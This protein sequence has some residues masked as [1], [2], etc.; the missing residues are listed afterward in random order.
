M[1]AAPSIAMKKQD[2]LP[3]SRFP[4]TSNQCLFPVHRWKIK[5]VSWTTVIVIEQHNEHSIRFYLTT[6][7]KLN[8]EKETVIIN[9]FSIK[10]KLM[11]LNRNVASLWFLVSQEQKVILLT[12]IC[13]DNSDVLRQASP[14]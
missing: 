13:H 3:V 10:I 11:H 9:Y 6:N 14:S 1:A 8:A 12:L 5:I 2:E 7:H 4:H